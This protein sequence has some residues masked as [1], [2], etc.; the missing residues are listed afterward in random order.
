MQLESISAYFLNPA[1]AAEILETPAAVKELGFNAGVDSLDGI[2]LFENLETLS[3]DYSEIDNVDALI[4]VGHLKNLSMHCDETLTDFTVLEKLSDLEKLS[5]TADGLK[6]I[7]FVSRL[8]NL[9]SLEITG[10][11]LRTL[12]GLENCLALRSLSVT[13][14]MELKD[15]SAVSELENLQELALEV[16]YGCPEPNLAKLTGLKKL[17]LDMF[18]DCTAIQNMTELTELHLYG[19]CLT[20]GLDLSRLTSLKELSCTSFTGFEL[21]MAALEPFGMLERLDLCGASTY[22]DISGLFGMPNL[23]ELNISGMQCEID[24]DAITENSTLE[25]LYMDDMYLYKNVWVEYYSGLTIAD[26]DEV[27]LD[28]HMEFIQKFPELKELY[29]RENGLTDLSFAEGLSALEVLDISDNYITQ[30]RPLAKLPSLQKVICAGNP[31]KD[32]KVL[33]DSVLI[34]K[35]A[36]SK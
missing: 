25:I 27:V 26:W 30:L 9:Y 3:F 28:E 24:F 31:L 6:T 4:H 32:E 16:P 11:K 10:G 35:E 7:D 23:K 14:C 18:Q 8:G 5:L 2:D 15:M 17:S 1:E 29:L 33:N 22:D 13:E 12:S 19:G 21:D 34:I 36:E 20:K